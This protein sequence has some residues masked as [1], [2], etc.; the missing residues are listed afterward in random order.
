[1]VVA[2]EVE[3]VVVLLVEQE[4]VVQVEQVV[5]QVEMVA[6]IV[7]PE[8]VVLAHKVVR[9]QVGQ[10]LVHKVDWVVEATADTMANA[11]TM[12][13]ITITIKTATMVTTR[14]EIEESHVYS[15]HV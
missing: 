7:E 4:Q 15:L 2:L 1:M 3:P 5:Q 12:G 11:Y 8:P 13:T 10:V 6:E 14:Y 9:D